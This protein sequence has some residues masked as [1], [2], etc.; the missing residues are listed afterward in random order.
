MKI[1]KGLY[2][3]IFRLFKLIFKKIDKYIVVPITKFILIITERN[4][5]GNRN[6]ERWLTRKNTLVFISL[7]L[8]L[9]FFFVVDNKT[10]TLVESSVE[11]LRNQKIEATYNTEAYVVE[12]L[13]TEV[14]VV[15]IGRRA[16]LFLAKQLTTKN[17]T[18]DLSGLKPGTHKVELK[19]ENDVSRIDYKLDP[20]T[21]NITIYPKL[22]ESRT[23]TVDVL[24]Q[25]TLNTKLAIQSVDIDQKEIIIKGAEHR[26]KQVSTVK[27]LV[28]I[29][30][31]VDPSVGVTNLSDVKLVAYDNNGNVVDVEMVPNKVVATI[32]IISPHKEVPI[33]VI[34]VGDVEFGKAISSIT[35]SVTKVTIY[36]NEDVINSIQYIPVEVD[37]TGLNNAKTYNA[38]LN[39]PS[40]IRYISESS[41]TV[42]VSLDKEITKEF[43]DIY[44]EVTNL[45]SNY[46]VVAL[47]KSSNTTSVIVK[48]TESVLNSIDTSMIKATIDL[49]GFGIGEHEV[50]VN[51]SGEE[52]R[53]SYT[54]KTTKVKVKII[55]K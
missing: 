49:T 53:A 54:P 14:D 18:V 35:S 22:S 5:K 30:N 17:V 41:T 25:D 13:P 19:Y 16:D 36:G 31:I 8:A 42:N 29:G 39:K 37:V 44:I 7:I 15:L 27:A 12:G 45:D 46:K 2:R 47:D 55:N 20:S 21:A 26:L 52:V 34:P 51:V 10:Y 11:V 40:G 33:K 3:G 4:G 24:N 9:G 50:T 23:T 6:F 38:I 43:E 32:S 28:D 1:I 48:G